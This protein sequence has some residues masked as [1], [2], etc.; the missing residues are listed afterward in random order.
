MKKALQKIESS[1]VSLYYFK[2]GKRIEGVPEDIR[3]DVSGIRG[4]VNGIIGN[5]D[6]C[7]ITDKE[8]KVVV[9]IQDLVKE[10]L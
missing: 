10:N 1:N 4:N 2:D 9:D 8:R 6:D 3:G 5:L 7:E